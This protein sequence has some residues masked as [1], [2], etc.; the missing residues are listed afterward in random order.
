VDPAVASGVIR[1]LA[2]HVRRLIKQV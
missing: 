1:T 2:R